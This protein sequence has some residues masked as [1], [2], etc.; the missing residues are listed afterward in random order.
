MHV[1]VAEN[2]VEKPDWKLELSNLLTD[3]SELC[4]LLD[5]DGEDAEFVKQA[6]DTF[7]LRIPRPFLSR[8][9]KSDRNDP[10]LLQ[11]LPQA[12]ELLETTGFMTDP[13]DESAFTPVPGLLHKYH[14]RVLVV[15]NGSCSIHCRYCFRRHFP[16]QEHRIGQEQWQAILDY[17]AKDQSIEEVIFSG[18][19]PMTCSDKVLASRCADLA[20][21]THVVRLRLHTRLPVMIPSRINQSCLQWMRETRL[22]VVT[23]IHSNHE[24]EIDDK[25]GEALAS[26]SNAGATVLNQSVLLRGINDQAEALAAL[27]KRLFQYGTLPYYLHLFDPVQRAA[28][29]KTNTVPGFGNPKT[30]ASVATR[31]SGAEIGG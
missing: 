30:T 11:V 22:Q 10:L 9:N 23:V 31:V 26:I 1:A 15:M 21:I 17:I 29:F 6:A 20:A 3:P 4:D 25:V 28:H 5:L 14:G 2:T 16:Y 27:S 19:D 24:N 8:I 12:A 7:P 18:G 13:L